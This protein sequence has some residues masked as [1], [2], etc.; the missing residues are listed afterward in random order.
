M[1][2]ANVPLFWSPTK[3]AI[4]SFA[5][6]PKMAPTFSEF[7]C[8]AKK[9]NFTFLAHSWAEWMRYFDGADVDESCGL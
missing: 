3:F 2:N 5:Q 8:D 9:H 6:G 7:R 4:L 1:H